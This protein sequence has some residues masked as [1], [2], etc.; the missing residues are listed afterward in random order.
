MAAEDKEICDL[1]EWLSLFK[2]GGA[3]KVKEHLI[4][5]QETQGNKHKGPKHQDV[6][7][8]PAPIHPGMWH[9]GFSSQLCIVFE[10]LRT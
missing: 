2:T 7:R 8:M 9:T 6:F 10:A 3:A 1:W 4:E 5:L